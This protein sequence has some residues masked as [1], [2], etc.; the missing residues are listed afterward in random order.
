M[1]ECVTDGTVEGLTKMSGFYL[2]SVCFESV[3]YVNSKS[4]KLWE[5]YGWKNVLFIYWNAANS[6]LAHISQLGLETHMAAQIYRQS[7]IGC[8]DDDE[9]F[10]L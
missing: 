9:N 6:P 4:E 7:L 10:T 3:L 2:V 8:W 1:L 5:R